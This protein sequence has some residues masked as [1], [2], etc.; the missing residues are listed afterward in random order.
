VKLVA[1]ALGMLLLILSAMD[2]KA[3]GDGRAVAAAERR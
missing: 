1:M 2:M 3:A